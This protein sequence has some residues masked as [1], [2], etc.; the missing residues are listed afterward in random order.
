YMSI[1]L[2]RTLVRFRGNDSF[3]VCGFKLTALLSD[4]AR[5]AKSGVP[6]SVARRHPAPGGDAQSK[7]KKETSCTLRADQHLASCW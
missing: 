6:V 5:H 3:T 1:K 4:P 7:N 2:F